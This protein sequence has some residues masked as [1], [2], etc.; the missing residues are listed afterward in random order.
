MYYYK[1]KLNF[2]LFNNN[3]PLEN[4]LSDALSGLFLKLLTLKSEY[5][6]F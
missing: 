2:I 3:F 5:S 1:N 4:V 6:F